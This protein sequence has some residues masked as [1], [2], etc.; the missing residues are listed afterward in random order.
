[1]AAI[2][3]LGNAMEVLPLDPSIKDVAVLNVGAAAE[4]RPFHK[5]LFRI[6]ASGRVP[7]GERPAGSGT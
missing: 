6:Y 1:M 7:I 5:Q 2:T 4:V 3:V